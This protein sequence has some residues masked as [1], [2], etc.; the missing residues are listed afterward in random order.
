M[1]LYKEASLMMLPTSVKDGKL[2]SIFPQPKPLSG[3][4][5]TNGDFSNGENGWTTNSWEVSGGKLILPATST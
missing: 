3:E 1:K 4:L 2:Y 5:V